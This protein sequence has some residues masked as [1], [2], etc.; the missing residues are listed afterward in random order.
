MGERGQVG[1]CSH[2][3][4]PVGQHE[5]RHGLAGHVHHHLHQEPMKEKVKAMKRKFEEKIQE[6]EI[7]RKGLEDSEETEKIHDTFRSKKTEDEEREDRV[8]HFPNQHS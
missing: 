1:V 6:E 2:P 8:E 5:D 4:L 7:L 3:G